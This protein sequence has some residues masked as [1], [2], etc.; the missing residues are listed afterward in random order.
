[1]RTGYAVYSPENGWWSGRS[2]EPLDDRFS[3]SLRDACVMGTE[4]AA[5]AS[6]VALSDRQDG[7]GVM[8]Y[9]V[10]FVTRRVGG[11]W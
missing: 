5:W 11:R 7:C 8:V 4:S 10:T 3:E 2:G 9:L 6:A 1:M